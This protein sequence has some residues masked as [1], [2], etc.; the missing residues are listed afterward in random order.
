MKKLPIVCIFSYFGAIKGKY[1]LRDKIKSD[2]MPWT[3]INISTISHSVYIMK[4]EILE[5]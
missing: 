3:H 5:N 2:K 1:T 4:V